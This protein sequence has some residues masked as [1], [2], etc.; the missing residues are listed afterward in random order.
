MAPKREGTLP[1][2]LTSDNNEL[3]KNSYRPCIRFHGDD[4]A[5]VYK[6]QLSLGA[7]LHIYPLHRPDQ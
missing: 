2:V 3:F 6:V 1:L 7:S 5:L 4:S